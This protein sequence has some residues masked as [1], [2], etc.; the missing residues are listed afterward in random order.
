MAKYTIFEVV[1]ST[2]LRSGFITS[3][4]SKEEVQEIVEAADLNANYY[5]ITGPKGTDTVHD[6]QMLLEYVMNP[7]LG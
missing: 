3:A 7:D 5:S 4:E 2:G 1:R 6:S